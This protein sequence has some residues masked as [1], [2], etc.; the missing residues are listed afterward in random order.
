MKSKFF[1]LMIALLGFTATS[2]SAQTTETTPRDGFYD[3]VAVKE[4][5][6]MPYDYVSENDV[7]WHKRIWRVID[8][9]EKMNLPFRYEGIDWKNLSPLITTLRDGALSG[10]ITM[11]DDE[12][13]KKPLT[14]A[15]VQRRGAG[16]DTI[17][18]QDFEGNP[19]HDTV[20]EHAFDPNKVMHYRVKED[21]FFNKKTSQMQV[22][23]IGIAP[24]Y[25]DEEAKIEYPLFWVYYAAARNTLAKAEVFNMRNDAQRWSF[26]DLFE[27][28]MFS[29]TI[30]KES[31]VFDRRIQDYATGVDALRES[32]RV[33]ED[34]F[35]YEHDL[36][37]F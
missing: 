19:T 5:Q 32:D 31:N 10:E 1:Y 18:L 37:S 7:Y 33:K 17:M 2:I 12:N 27:M 30:I 29:S 21:W 15:D 11:Y 6:A 4:R 25:Y 24:M 22:R 23:I 14:V 34:I 28:R 26:E 35:N 36:W 3:E 16:F 13:F 9:H 8:V 20:V